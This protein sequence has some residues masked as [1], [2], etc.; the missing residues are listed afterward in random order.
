MQPDPGAYE[1][2]FLLEYDL[3]GDRSIG[4]GDLVVLLAAWG[5]CSGDCAADLDGNGDVGFSDLLI[6][7][8]NWGWCQAPTSPPNE[9]ADCIEKLGTSDPQQLAACIEAMMRLE[10][11][12]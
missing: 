9:I 1:Y 4:F 2:C 8:A 3:D 10:E 7:I 11:G 6:V 12:D 5:P